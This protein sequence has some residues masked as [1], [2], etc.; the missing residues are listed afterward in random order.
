MSEKVSWASFINVGAVGADH[1]F[2]TRHSWNARDVPSIRQR[3]L[4]DYDASLQQV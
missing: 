2:L 3:I 1:P 4:D